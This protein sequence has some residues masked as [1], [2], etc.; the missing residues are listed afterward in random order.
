MKNDTVSNV[1]CIDRVYIMPNF[2]VVFLMGPTASGKT[3]TALYLADHFPCHLVSC[4]SALIYKDMDIGTAKPNREILTRYPHALVDILSPMERY[5]A[6]QFRQDA[7]DEIETARSAGKMPVIVG[8]T[9]L[10]MKSLIEGISPIPEVKPEIRQQLMERHHAEGIEVLYRELQQLDSES[11]ERLAP[12]DTQRI[13]RALEVVLSSGQTLNDF[14]KMPPKEALPYPYLKF[15]LTYQ[16]IQRANAGMAERFNQMIEQGLVAEV[17]H[18]KTAYPEL[19]GDYPSQR[20]VGYRQIWDYLDGLMTKEEAI[21][22]A[23]IATRQYAKRQR[24]WL[25]SE[26]NLITMSVENPEFRSQ[27]RQRIEEESR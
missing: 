13:L 24:T 5:S 21:E 27:I 7:R 2:P 11:A 12:A 26:T 14:W 4:D 1:D 25:R 18:L 6:E 19:N 9:F 22:R 17:E 23:I 3:D 15:A 16:D 8:G 20:A 10:Y